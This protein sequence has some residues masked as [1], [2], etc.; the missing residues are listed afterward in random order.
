VLLWRVKKFDGQVFWA[1]VILYSIVRGGILE[2]FRGDHRVHI[3]GLSGQQYL[4]VLTLIVGVV[5]YVYLR[6]RALA[7]GAAHQ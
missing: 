3:L 7:S 5:I 4:S 1:Y 6:R 2:W